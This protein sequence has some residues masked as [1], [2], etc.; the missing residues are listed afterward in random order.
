LPPNADLKLLDQFGGAGEQHRWYFKPE[1][2]YRLHVD[3]QDQLG[4]VLDWQITR[5]G[6]LEYRSKSTA[7]GCDRG[8]RY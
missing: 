2:A 5:F 1:F 3:D 6:S 4:R 7:F 8:A